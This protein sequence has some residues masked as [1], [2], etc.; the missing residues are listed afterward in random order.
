MS[1]KVS[2]LFKRAML[3][4]AKQGEFKRC[5][6]MHGVWIDADYAAE[7]EQGILDMEENYKSADGSGVQAF[8]FIALLGPIAEHEPVLADAIVMM[9]AMEDE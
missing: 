5:A 8:S 7:M 2:T 9:A 4:M 6:E 3:E 1:N